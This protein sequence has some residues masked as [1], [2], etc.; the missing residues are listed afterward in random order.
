MRKL[1]FSF[2][3]IAAVL[4]CS[5]VGA[6]LRAQTEPAA[7][8][9]SGR[10]TDL[11][12]KPIADAQVITTAAGSGASRTTTTDQDGHYRIY[13]PGAA[14]QYQVQV[15]RLG[16]APVQRTVTRR[17]G[18]A[19]R[20][21]IDIELGGTPLALS[22]VEINGT[23][24]APR[25]SDIKKTSAVDASIP[26]PIAEILTLKD[27]LHLSAVQIVGLGELSDTLQTRNATIYRSIQTLLA[28]SAE[29]GD[30]TQM[31]GSVAMM[32][33]EAAGNTS[34]AVVAA[35]KLLRPE[36]W[37]LLPQTIR[38]RPETETSSTAKQ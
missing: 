27:T 10:V 14:P 30:A 12:G 29:A 4:A 32:L 16:F 11:T 26:N 2:P 23:P 9:L 36:Q 13:F 24:D 1:A 28:K 34:H 19:E 6:P 31:A 33:E 38:D 3:C 5:L 8:V 22:M 21:T 20:M 7:D 37:E 35:K 17:S 25:L 15:K 18:G